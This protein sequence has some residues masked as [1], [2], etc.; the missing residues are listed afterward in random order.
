MNMYLVEGAAL[1]VQLGKSITHLTIHA[2]YVMSAV[3]NVDG[4][5]VV[6]FVVHYMLWI[7]Q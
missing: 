2:F 4:G 6:Q 1:F 7:Q 5:K 3:H